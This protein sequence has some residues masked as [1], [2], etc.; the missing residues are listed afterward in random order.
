MTD[1]MFSRIGRFFRELGEVVATPSG[2]ARGHVKD[3]FPKPAP[4]EH[5]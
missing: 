3:Y 5:M 1:N 2:D 4:R